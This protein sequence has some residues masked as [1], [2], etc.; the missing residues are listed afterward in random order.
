MEH[1]IWHCDRCAKPCEYEDPEN[2][3]VWLS[4]DEKEAEIGKISTCQ[5]YEKV[6]DSCGNDF[7]QIAQTCTKDCANCP[8][9]QVWGLSVRECLT[10][11]HTHKLLE[12][13]EVSAEMQ[14]NAAAYSPIFVETFTLFSLKVAI[15]KLKGEV[16]SN[17]ADFIALEKKAEELQDLLRKNTHFRYL[18]QL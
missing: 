6:C 10:F 12:I 17:H 15:E 4:Y 5:S 3:G 18:Q 1:K 16:S 7:Y 8:T 14:S 11:Q 2:L 9:T 13:S